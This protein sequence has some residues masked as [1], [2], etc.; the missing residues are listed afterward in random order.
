MHL[1]SPYFITKLSEPDDQP[2]EFQFFACFLRQCQ[3]KYGADLLYCP[4]STEIHL[5]LD[6]GKCRHFVWQQTENNILMAT[7]AEVPWGCLQ[8]QKL[9]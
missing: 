3:K 6:T 9:I 4:A 2:S 7:T 1:S 8:G 5:P